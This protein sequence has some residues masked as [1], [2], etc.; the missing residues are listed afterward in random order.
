MRERRGCGT[1]RTNVLT[2]TAGGSEKY[3]CSERERERVKTKDK[4]PCGDLK[5]CAHHFNPKLNKKIDT[6][7]DT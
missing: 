7:P 1:R 3:N 2:V 6:F 5:K 4:S